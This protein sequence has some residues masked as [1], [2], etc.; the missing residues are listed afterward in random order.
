MKIVSFFK[1]CEED[2]SDLI[3]IQKNQA[4][5]KKLPEYIFDLE[6]Q[7]N[8][9]RTSMDELMSENAALK[10]EIV[11]LD[12]VVESDRSSRNAAHDGSVKEVE[13]KLAAFISNF[14]SNSSDTEKRLLRLENEN[15]SLAR[16]IRSLAEANRV[17][18]ERLSQNEIH[19]QKMAD[20]NQKLVEQIL[21]LNTENKSQNDRIW[22]IVRNIPTAKTLGTYSVQNSS[23]QKHSSTTLSK[24]GPLEPSKSE[25]NASSVIKPE[26]A[27]K[28]EFEMS[29][30][31]KN[32]LH[33]NNLSKRHVI[34]P[35]GIEKICTICFF[36]CKMESIA[37]P[38]GVECI[39]E[40]AFTSC[41]RLREVILPNSTRK[42]GNRAFSNC[43]ALESII[44]PKD[45]TDIGADAFNDC[46]KLTIKCAANSPAEKYAKKAKIPYLITFLKSCTSCGFSTPLL[47][48]KKCPVC[49][50]KDWKNNF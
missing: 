2:I 38:E 1:L 16:Q 37:I 30:D 50:A 36:G 33:Y 26:I 13:R 29:A 15:S 49:G 45:V 9:V 25:N 21:L 4:L 24:A 32:L 39:D 7:L 46:P 5:M 43:S 19:L 44:I 6:Q 20:D 17:L 40:A 48:K 35:I 8:G 41:N 47:D 27:L 42:L 18:N 31:G 11:R 23:D 34:I 12:K 22:N 3:R 14:A 28:H 10:Q